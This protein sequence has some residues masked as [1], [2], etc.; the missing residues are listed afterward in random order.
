M[1]E[2]EYACAGKDELMSASEINQIAT[3]FVLVP[4]HVLLIYGMDSEKC[5]INNLCEIS[6]VALNSCFFNSLHYYIFY[7]Q[8]NLLQFEVKM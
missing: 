5:S 4:E 3:E 1:P 6:A 8:I 7:P 2:E